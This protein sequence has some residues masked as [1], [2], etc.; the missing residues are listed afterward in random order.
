LKIFRGKINF[1]LV[2]PF[3]R[4]GHNLKGLK[5]GTF[6][7]S[8]STALKDFPNIPNLSEGYTLRNQKGHLVSWHEPLSETTTEVHVTEAIGG[9]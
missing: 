2:R 8:A 4:F 3:T 1:P 5:E 6:T 9:G 7:A